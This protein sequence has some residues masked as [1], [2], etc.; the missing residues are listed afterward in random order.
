MIFFPLGEIR[1]MESFWLRMRTTDVLKSR[2]ETCGLVLWKCVTAARFAKAGMRARP[3]LLAWTAI[4]VFVVVSMM[5]VFL[6][7]FEGV[8]ALQHS[9]TD[10][11]SGFY[12][13]FGHDTLVMPNRPT[14]ARRALHLLKAIVDLMAQRRA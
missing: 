7:V 10:R 4:P 11:P 14:R 9:S 12:H 2:P 5:R 13:I 8:D 3:C 1:C 6:R